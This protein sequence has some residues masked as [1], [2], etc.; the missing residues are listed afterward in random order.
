MKINKPFPTQAAFGHSVLSQ[1]RTLPKTQG[2]PH[3]PVP[4]PAPALPLNP[5]TPSWFLLTTGRV[6][7]TLVAIG[8]VPVHQWECL[9]NVLSKSTFRPL[10]VVG[11]WWPGSD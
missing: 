8:M 4:V 6:F 11:G 9:E 1:K 5:S 10:G 7:S 3:T 2:L